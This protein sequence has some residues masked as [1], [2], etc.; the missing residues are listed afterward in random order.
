MLARSLPGGGA[1]A[2]A[3]P[4]PVPAGTTAS[5]TNV[6][7]RR[8]CT[9]PIGCPVSYHGCQPHGVNV[10]GAEAGYGPAPM[11]TRAERVRSARAEQQAAAQRRR[12]ELVAFTC[13]GCR[14]VLAVVDA[15]GWMTSPTS[16]SDPDG[17]GDWV[18]WL[19]DG[20]RQD[21]GLFAAERLVLDC[22]RSRRARWRAASGWCSRRRALDVPGYVGWRCRE[23]RDVGSVKQLDSG[24]RHAR[25]R[26]RRAR[27]ARAALPAQ[28]GSAAVGL[29]QRRRDVQ[30]R[31]DRPA[32]RDDVRGVRRDLACRPA[33]APGNGR[34][35]AIA[36]ARPPVPTVGARPLGSVRPSEVQAFA[37]ALAAERS[38]GTVR[39]VVALG[40]GGTRRRWL[41]AWSPG[42][43]SPR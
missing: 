18:R 20:G 33:L 4:R 15:S 26:T 8:S 23:G 28:G 27:A 7:R 16:R 35:P 38:A 24:M 40:R 11:T 12:D 37:R 43:R 41:T 34:A 30:G 21:G 5:V 17:M 39:N 19:R 2:T 31:L 1:S 22:P 32:R 3:V 42:H 14:R 29:G 25:Y 13:P 6:W 10:R 36:A 9:A